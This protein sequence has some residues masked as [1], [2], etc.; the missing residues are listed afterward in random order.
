MPGVNPVGTADRRWTD[1]AE[2]AG[3]LE[4]GKSP[5]GKTAQETKKAQ[6]P[7]VPGKVALTGAFVSAEGISAALEGAS[8]VG[9]GATAAILGPGV[10]LAKLL[11]G[12]HKAHFEG[13][14]LRDAHARDAVN[15]AFVYAA[16]EALPP[17][18]VAHIRGKMQAVDGARGGAMKIV[19]R[20]RADKEWQ[21]MQKQAAEHVRAGRAI[22][23]RFGVTTP[24]A[25]EARLKSDR[26][27]ALLY[28]QNLGFKHG[29]DSVLYENA[30]RTQ[31][32]G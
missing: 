6:Q 9:A 31:G 12:F 23:N 5:H 27:F 22:A 2:R 1:T 18:Y 8:G 17:G 15:L 21:A 7:S 26:N 25:L 3:V 13:E 14:E 28:S 10:T 16:A 19:N 29:V 11:V 4:K 24:Q 30:H 20:A 32:A